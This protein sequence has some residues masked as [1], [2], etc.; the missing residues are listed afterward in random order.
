V[1]E[2]PF[3]R[4]GIAGLGLIG[5]SI[6]LG[7]RR[8]W[9]SIR[10]V[11]F[12]RSIAA[13]TEAIGGVVH[14]SVSEIAGLQG[15][16]LIVLAT[17]L[18][19]MSGLMQAI[20]GFGSTGVVTDVGSTKRQVMA[21]SRSAGLNRFVG[22]HPMGGSERVGLNYANADLFEGRPWLLV[23]GDASER[24]AQSVERLATALGAVSQ[25]TDAD[26]HDR[27]V[28]YVSHLPQVI[29]VALMNAATGAVGDVGLQAAGRAFSEMTRLAASP[30]D[31]WEGILS[32]NSDF[33]VE[34]LA[35]FMESLPGDGQLG[36]REWVREAFARASA[37]RGRVRQEP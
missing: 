6:A 11:G 21:A 24:D 20:A 37:A 12:D 36:G 1:S 13:T 10:V 34:A 28:A 30:A 27:I 22:G 25:W 18:A 29:A 14:E 9:P 32:D 8:A 33:I 31:L 5:G 19:A 23:R 15:C 7:V 26:T 2:P 3:T 4:V 17:P 35:R 16:D